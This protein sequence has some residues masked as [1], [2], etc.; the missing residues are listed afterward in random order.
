MTEDNKSP[1]A[2]NLLNSAPTQKKMESAVKELEKVQKSQQST[3]K[4]VEKQQAVEAQIN[5]TGQPFWWMLLMFI[6]SLVYLFPEA[7]FNAALTDVAGGRNSSMEDLRLVELF[8]RSI[9]GIGVTLLLADLLLKGKRVANVTRALGYFALIAVLVWPTVFFGQKWLVD[10][11]IIDASTPEERQ[12]AYLSQLLRSALIENSITFEGIEYDPDKEHSAIEKTFLS[13]FG[14]L[15][16]ADDKLVDDLKDKKRLIMEKFVRDRAMS[17]FDEHYDHYDNFRQTLRNKYTEYASGSNQYN[18]ALASVQTRSDSYWLDTQNQVKQGWEQYQKGTKAYEARVESRAQKMAPKLYDYFERRNKCAEKKSGSSKDRCFERLQKGYDKEI[19]KYSIPYIPPNDWLIREEIST[20][21]NVG[22]S[23]ISGIMSLGL[24]TAMQAAD[25]ITGGD[26][27]FKDHRMVYT[28]DVNHYKR[29][30]MV[31]MAPDFAKESGGYPLGIN[32]IHEFRVHELTSIKV[33]KKL[34]Q[35]GLTLSPSWSITDRNSFDIAVAKKVR[36]QADAEWRSKMKAKGSDMPPNLSWQTFQQQGVIQ[37]R[38][39][40]EMKELYVNPTLADWNNREFKQHIIEPNIKRKTTEYLNVLE[41]QQAEF[42]DGGSFESTGK[43]ALRSTII[44][45][46]SMAIS[47]ALVLLTVLKLPMKA[48]EL[49]QAKRASSAPRVKPN[50]LIKPVI[51]TVLLASIFVVPLSMGGNQYTMP[52]SSLHYF[53]DQMEKNDSATVSYTLKWLLVTLPMVQPVGSSIDQ[54]LF[55]TEGFNA[56]SDPIN[57]FDLAVMPTHDS[58]KTVTS[59]PKSS[60]L[61]PLTINS[62]I[63]R[64]KVS[65]MNIKPKYQAGMM[66]PAG[67]Y[68]I[69]VSAPG[70]EP[71]RKWVYLKADETSFEINF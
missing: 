42:A 52:G 23:I 57:R 4:K 65:V 31:K 32:S 66:L 11:F 34:K 61:L 18:Q 8:G 36:Q 14:G 21:E 26:A 59:S 27:G 25:A 12:Q 20:S 15:V 16:Y 71:I 6:C 40:R 54:R 38:I 69:K 64:A 46:I 49:V 3:A 51:S 13:V 70:Q 9:S 50:R 47:L 37:Q 44:P 22:N 5:K 19:A 58:T 33:N 53:F 24:F 29:V 17:R 28:N 41:A 7:V 56:I 30:L 39:K 2:T 63:A 68:D 60:A 35:K 1:F 43:S 67:S 45:P 55:I 48:V 10:H 62:N